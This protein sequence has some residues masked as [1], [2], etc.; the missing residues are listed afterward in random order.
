MSHIS[1]RVRRPW[2]AEILIKGLTKRY[3]LVLSLDYQIQLLVV[4]LLV[5]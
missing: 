4:K 3:G 5:L 1:K 2:T